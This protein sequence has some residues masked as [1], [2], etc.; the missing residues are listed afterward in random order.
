MVLSILAPMQIAPDTETRHVCRH[1]YRCRSRSTSCASNSSD[2]RRLSA[3]SNRSNCLRSHS[4][5]RRDRGSSSCSTTY[6]FIGE[7]VDPL[8]SDF[9]KASQDAR[10]ESAGSDRRSFDPGGARH[11]HSA[12]RNSADGTAAVLHSRSLP[13]RRARSRSHCCRALDLEMP[14]TF[15]D[16]DIYRVQ[17]AMI[18]QCEQTMSRVAIIDPPLSAVRDERLGN[19]RRAGLAQSVRFHVRRFLLSRGSA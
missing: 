9:V 17:A 19:L 7:P 2:S 4:A 12:D 13:S 16:A 3:R 6:D 15:T 8:D 11:Q 14:P 5:H 10:P 1:L 18:E